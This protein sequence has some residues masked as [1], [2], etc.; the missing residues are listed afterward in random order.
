MPKDG[1]YTAA[2]IAARRRYMEKTYKKLQIMVKPTEY[3]EIDAYCDMKKIS[4]K[5]FIVR[6]CNYFIKRDE[7]PPESEEDDD[8]I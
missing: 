5:K 4:K 6:A 1:K 3:T 2:E 7:L 8:A